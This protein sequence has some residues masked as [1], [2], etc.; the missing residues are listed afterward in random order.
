MWQPFER[1]AASLN[2]TPR[3]GRPPEAPDRA[4]V[5]LLARRPANHPDGPGH[6]HSL[7][8][9]FVLLD[10]L[11]TLYQA[12]CFCAWGIRPVRRQA[13]LVFD[14]HKLTYLS[15]IERV[16][17]LFC[18]GIGAASRRFGANSRDERT[19]GAEVALCAGARFGVSKSE[20]DGGYR[21]SNLIADVS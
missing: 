4:V 12:I 17:C 1:C 3:C 7:A 8:I 18:P 5:L 15:G 20:T 13:Y 16:H 11:V 9:S 14:R 6:I 2:A 19:G 10:A 21:P